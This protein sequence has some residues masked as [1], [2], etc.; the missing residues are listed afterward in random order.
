[1]AA[2]GK[3]TVLWTAHGTSAAGGTEA[4]GPLQPPELSKY[5][6]SS[7][8]MVVSKSIEKGSVSPVATWSLL[9][10]GEHDLGSQALP[11]SKVGTHTNP[12]S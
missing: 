10:P 6:S 3:R 12:M 5:F 1:M 9:R 7:F 8:F 11:L 2:L 4:Q